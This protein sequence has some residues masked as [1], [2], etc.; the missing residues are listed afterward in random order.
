LSNKDRSTT[1]GDGTTIIFS[2]EGDDLP[3]V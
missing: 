2:T 3:I 1:T